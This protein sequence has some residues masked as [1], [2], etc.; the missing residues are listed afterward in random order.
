MPNRVLQFPAVTYISTFSR[1]IFSSVAARITIIL[2]SDVIRPIDISVLVIISILELAANVK[3]N[4]QR[5]ICL[6]T[7]ILTTFL[8]HF[9]QRQ[10]QILHLL[11]SMKLI[12]KNFI[13]LLILHNIYLNLKKIL[14]YLPF[15]SP[16]QCIVSQNMMFQLNSV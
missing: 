11:S 13:Y 4:Y 12:N 5:I 14:S 3:P 6:Q 2:S 9:R 10:A 16:R 15:G 1:L 7:Q 8:I